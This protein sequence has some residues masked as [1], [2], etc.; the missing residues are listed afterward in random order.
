MYQKQLFLITWM[1]IGIK[2]AKDNKIDK[3]ATRWK[4]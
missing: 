2:N 1:V 3:G 4:Q